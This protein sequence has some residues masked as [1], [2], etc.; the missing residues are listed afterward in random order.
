MTE[1]EA[2]TNVTAK[3]N[4]WLSD[5]VEA[6]D[7]DH[8]RPAGKG[9]EV[10]SSYVPQEA[11]AT[12]F[13]DGMRVQVLSGGTLEANTTNLT[14]NSLAI[15]AKSAGV[16]KGLSFG[17]TGTLDVRN[18]DEED[19]LPGAYVDC[20]GFENLANWTLLFD[21]RAKAGRRA[22]VSNG[23]IVI[24]KKGISITIK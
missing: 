19:T 3:Y 18:W 12:Q 1:G 7:N 17:E 23:T 6:K 21:G 11:A 8:A 2:F 13:P 4:R 22:L 16:I 20:E 9:F 24:L 14:V 5:G 15:D 10:L